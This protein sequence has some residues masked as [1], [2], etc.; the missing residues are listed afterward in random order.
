[1]TFSLVLLG[2]I[3]SFVLIL[4]VIDA[5]RVVHERGL[6]PGRQL[7]VEQCRG[8][9]PASIRRRCSNSRAVSTRGNGVATSFTRSGRSILA[10]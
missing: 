4:A 9:G 2:G 5:R 7:F 8:I 6:P 3:T 10:R 1:M